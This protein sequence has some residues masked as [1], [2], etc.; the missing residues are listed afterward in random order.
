M[1]SDR[2]NGGV[3]VGIVPDAVT[4]AG[5][6]AIA[7][8]VAVVDSDVRVDV[9]SCCRMIT[10]DAVVVVVG[11]QRFNGRYPVA[12]VPEHEGSCDVGVNV[13]EI[14]AVVGIVVVVVDDVE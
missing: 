11:E 13:E 2:H 8:S 4:P 5:I 12:P 14:A 10:A 1:H 6:I 7:T 9:D 3:A